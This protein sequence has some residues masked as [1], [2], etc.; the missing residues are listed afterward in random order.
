MRI[1]IA[2]GVLHIPKSGKIISS[3]LQPNIYQCHTGELI[4]E[5]FECDGMEDCSDGSEETNCELHSQQ[6]Y[7]KI[8]I[9]I[10][11]DYLLE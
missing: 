4:W 8:V 7:I 3:A 6:N 9:L 2:A 1:C 11:Q 10:G 5:Y